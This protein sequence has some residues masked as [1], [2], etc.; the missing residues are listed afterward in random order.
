MNKRIRTP[1]RGRHKNGD[2]FAMQYPKEKVWELLTPDICTS[3]QIAGTLGCDVR[4]AY[5]KLRELLDDGKVTQI[6]AGKVWI[7]RR[8]EGAG[9]L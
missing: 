5:A 7:W 8:V 1:P 2:G 6:R 9:T 4:T 3:S